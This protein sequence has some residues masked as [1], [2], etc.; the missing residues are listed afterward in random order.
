MGN[1][2]C[3]H[4]FG[5][6]VVSRGGRKIWKLKISGYNNNEQKP[7]ILIGIV[8]ESKIKSFI[9]Y[10]G[11]D[12]Y[13]NIIKKRNRSTFNDDQN[14]GY[15]LYTADW[16]VYHNDTK[17]IPFTKSYGGIDITPNDVI[18]VELDLTEKYSSSPS[19]SSKCGTLKYIFN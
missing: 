17:G 8:E 14:G 13:E 19:T 7:C 4:S 11:D 12:E 16:N 9:K 18:A 6:D 1:M 10:D 15:C 2:E 3:Y 5:N